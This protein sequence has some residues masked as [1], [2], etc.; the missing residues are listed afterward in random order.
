MLR[1]VSHLI[2]ELQCESIGSDRGVIIVRARGTLFEMPRSKSK[3]YHVKLEGDRIVWLS[4]P[5]IMSFV[6]KRRD[7]PFIL[8]INFLTFSPDFTVV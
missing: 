4:M 5:S 3:F 1:E 7:F 6:A 8:Y 2:V